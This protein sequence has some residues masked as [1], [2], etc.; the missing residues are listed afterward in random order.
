MFMACNCYTDFFSPR[1]E[2]IKIDSGYY[3]EC[4]LTPHSFLCTFNILYLALLALGFS[5][6]MHPKFSSYHAFYAIMRS[7]LLAS[8]IILYMH[9]NNNN[10]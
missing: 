8:I 2:F 6:P 1:L 5:H 10:S 3:R 9:T 7:L 4:F